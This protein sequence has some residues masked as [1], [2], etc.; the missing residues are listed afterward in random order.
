MYTVEESQ[1]K[2]ETISSNS[3]QIRKEKPS[4]TE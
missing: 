1:L 2:I 4:D 3:S